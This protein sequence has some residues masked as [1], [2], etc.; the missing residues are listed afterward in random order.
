MALGARGV[1]QVERTACRVR[2]GNQGHRR[3]ERRDRVL[4]RDIFRF[5]TATLFLLDQEWEC[6]PLQ[7]RDSLGYS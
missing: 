3:S 2:A 1:R 7:T 6:A 5:G 4:L